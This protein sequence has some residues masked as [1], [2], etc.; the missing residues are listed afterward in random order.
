MSE[1]LVEEDKNGK[2]EYKI[3]G[4]FYS[5]TS[6]IVMGVYPKEILMK[7]VKRYNK[8]FINKKSCIW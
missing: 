1:Y 3:K 2:K 4:V 5:L 7:E 6:R 8:E